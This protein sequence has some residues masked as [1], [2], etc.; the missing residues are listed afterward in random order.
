MTSPKDIESS[1]IRQYRK[2][3]YGKLHGLLEKAGVPTDLYVGIGMEM[4]YPSEEHK[5]WCFNV[6]DEQNIVVVCVWPKRLT[7]EQKGV[8]NR[9]VSIAK[10]LNYIV[11]DYTQLSKKEIE[12]L[13]LS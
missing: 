1:L 2:D 6:F 7:S 11:K 5:I 12:D 8:L 3:K 13:G 10:Q 9:S 4:Y